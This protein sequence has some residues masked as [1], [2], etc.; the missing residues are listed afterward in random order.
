[1]DGTNNIWLFFGTGRFFAAAD[2]T[3]TDIQHFFG[4]KDCIV[5]GGCTDQ[6]VERNN[7]FNSSNVVVCSSCAAGTKVSTTGRTSAFHVGFSAGGGNLVN[8]IQNMDGWFTT[9]NDPS[10]AFPLTSGERNVS[11]STLI[12][13]T[14][15]FTTF[16]PIADFCTPTGTGRL[17]AV[18]YLTGGPYTASAVGTVTSGSNSLAKKAVSLGQGLPSQMAIQI[19]AQ[20]TGAS[21]ASSSAGCTG[22]MTG[23]IQSSTGVLGQTCGTPSL[24]VWSRMESWRDM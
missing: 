7:L 2:K 24:S 8:S 14:V 22:R 18:F 12:G 4:V 23:F 10:Q 3:N 21:G 9:F 11:T 1:M 17:Y 16:T 5:T 20:G 15:F 19:G 6:S 13:G